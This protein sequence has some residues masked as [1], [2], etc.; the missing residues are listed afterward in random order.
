[1]WARR[2]ALMPVRRGVLALDDSSLPKQGRHSVGV[3]RQYR[4]ALGKTANCQ[5]AVSKVVLIAP[6]SST[7][8]N[9]QCEPSQ[10]T[11]VW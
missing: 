5:I 6:L 9:R 10:I 8:R 1:M 11:A 2:R 4:G 3:K 7:R